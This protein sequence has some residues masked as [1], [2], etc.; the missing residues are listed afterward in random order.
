M[1]K[2]RVHGGE[3]NTH[4]DLGVRYLLAPA[5]AKDEAKALPVETVQLPLLLSRGCPSFTPIQEGANKA[6]IVH[7]NLGWSGQLRILPDTSGQSSQGC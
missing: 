4:K 6:G 1:S 3:A 5:D 7:C 2:Q